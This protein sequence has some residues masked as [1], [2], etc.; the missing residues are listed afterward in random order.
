M[1]SVSSASVAHTIRQ[2][3][4]ESSTPT[5]ITCL[6]STSLCIASTWLVT[7][8]ISCPKNWRPHFLHLILRRS[9]GIA[10]TPLSTVSDAV[11]TLSG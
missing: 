3:W 1:C 2:S 6:A 5:S 9:S 11:E 7:S 4:Q 8:V 10:I